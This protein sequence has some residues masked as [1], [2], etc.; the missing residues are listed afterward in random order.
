MAADETVGAVELGGRAAW[1]VGAW[2]G[3]RVKG[4]VRIGWVARENYPTGCGASTGGR[5]E[6]RVS[7]HGADG[8][9]NELRA[10]GYG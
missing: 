10:S 6:G 9:E 8:G 5:I 1:T 7:R 4:V 3:Q 2:E